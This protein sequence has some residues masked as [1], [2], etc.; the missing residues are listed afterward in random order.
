MK[1]IILALSLL[2]LA[3]PSVFADSNSMLLGNAKKGKVIHDAHC[4]ACHTTTI[5][6]R[7]KRLV[8]SLSGLVGRVSACSSNI[9]ANLNNDQI[10]DVVKYLNDNFYKFSNMN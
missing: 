3:A 8:K 10:N 7:P 9:G 5:Y 6:T 1:R 2:T 4:T